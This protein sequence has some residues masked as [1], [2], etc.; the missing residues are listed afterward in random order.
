MEESHQKVIDE[1][2]KK[3]QRELEKLHDEKERLLD[4]ETAA[5]IAGQLP[6][7]RPSLTQLWAGIY[8]V[9][10]F[11]AKPTIESEWNLSAKLP[12]FMLARWQYGELERNTGQILARRKS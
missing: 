12:P 5:T 8:T 7:C 9:P 2:Q 4:E 10:V 1:L 3:H 11:A 6:A